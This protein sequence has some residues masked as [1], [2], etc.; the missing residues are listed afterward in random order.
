MWD[1]HINNVKN[2]IIE[3]CLFVTYIIIQ[4]ITNSEVKLHA[5]LE[6]WAADTAAP[7]EQ[8]GVRCLAQGSHLSR[9]QFLPELRFKP[10]TSDYKSN[11]LSI[12]PR[13]PPRLKEGEAERAGENKGNGAVCSLWRSLLQINFMVLLPGICVARVPE[14]WPQ[15]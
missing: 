3:F 11:T 15:N 7:G 10:T 14:F 9:G 12:R 6:Q 1:I 13:L 2:K 8:S 5:H 4:S